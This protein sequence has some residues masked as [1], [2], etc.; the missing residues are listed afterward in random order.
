[1][2]AS[3][4]SLNENAVRPAG[5]GG[6]SYSRSEGLDRLGVSM[7]S[8]AVFSRRWLLR[9]WS[10]ASSRVAPCLGVQPVGFADFCMFAHHPPL[11]PAR[12]EVCPRAVLE[13]RA[14]L[15]P[16]AEFKPRSSNRRGVMSARVLIDM[17]SNGGG[18]VTV[19]VAVP[20]TNDALRVL[21]V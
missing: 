8:R 9:G 16:R 20:A 13:P 17:R 4:C 19:T 21:G 2:V 10:C 1:M 12:A 6:E 5:G 7:V 14:E 18:A 11:E 3:A 15:N